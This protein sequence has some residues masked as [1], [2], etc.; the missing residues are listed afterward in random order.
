MTSGRWVLDRNHVRNHDNVLYHLWTNM[1]RRCTDSLD[2]DY[3]DYGGRGIVVCE[4]WNDFDTFVD[5]ILE[6][7]GPRPEG[8]TLDRVDNG[9]NY[10][11]GKVRWATPQEQVHNQRLRKKYS[12]ASSRYRGVKANN[13]SKT[14]PWRA[15]GNFAGKHYYLGHFPKEEDAARAYDAW[16]LTTIGS[17][18]EGFNFPE[19]VT[20]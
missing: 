6:E 7:I 18:Y 17:D 1:R 15:D 13:R 4:R 2:R 9:G 16:A 12:G 8:M 10:E 3:P 11:P 19:E 5:D 14:S 20:V